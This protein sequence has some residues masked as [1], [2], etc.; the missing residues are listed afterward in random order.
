MFRSIKTPDELR[1]FILDEATKYTNCKDSYFGGICWQEHDEIGC[2]WKISVAEGNDWN[3][4]I[5]HI[6]PFI[7]TLR[8]DYNIPDPH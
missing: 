3:K 1:E 2:N 8:H 7:K 4:C 5:E 6:M